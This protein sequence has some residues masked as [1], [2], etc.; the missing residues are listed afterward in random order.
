MDE[1]LAP[2]T[3]EAARV[4]QARAEHECCPPHVSELYRNWVGVAAVAVAALWALWTFVY[5]EIVQP[6]QV[7]V[8]ISLNLDLQEA[9]AVHKGFPVAL[10][11]R[12]GQKLV[13]VE[14]S[15]KATNP[16]SR[17]VFLLPSAWMARGYKVDRVQARNDFP[18]LANRRIAE[19]SPRPIEKYARVEK[20]EAIA[21]GRLF[22]DNELKPNESISR[23]IVFH[24]PLGPYD[25]VEV[26]TC[27]PSSDKPE[28]GIVW[29]FR[30]DELQWQMTRNGKP[31][32]EQAW[33]NAMAEE[34]QQ[35]VSRAA[36][37][38]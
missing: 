18:E 6:K 33:A 1:H 28:I 12:D 5:K 19:K 29:R 36:M 10:A 22:G 8:N 7:P 30:N 2:E 14:L 11:A 24:V 17:T 38:L 34:F 35:S 4:K 23:R 21:A 15:V 26:Y 32:P 16:S 9:S 27:V 25:V 37:S 13:S 20:S 31:I 3:K